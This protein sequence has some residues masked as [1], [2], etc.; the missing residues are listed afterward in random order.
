MFK[1]NSFSQSQSLLAGSG[2]DRSYKYRSSYLFTLI[3]WI[4]Y[5]F[6]S[7]IMLIWIIT[8]V[9]IG[10]FFLNI[11]TILS[12]KKA[13]TFIMIGLSPILL[14][15]VYVLLRLPTHRK[16]DWAIFKCN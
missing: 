1:T 15:M 11:H 16:L 14:V 6:I 12:K 2:K 8:F 4:K 13:Y 7:L 9:G 3:R 5:V 10:V